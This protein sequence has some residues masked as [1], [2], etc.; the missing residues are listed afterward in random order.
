MEKREIGNI[1]KSVRIGLLAFGMGTPPLPFHAEWSRRRR[2]RCGRKEGRKE[3]A[4]FIPGNRVAKFHGYH[5]RAVCGGNG[6]LEGGREGG[7]A[8]GRNKDG[9]AVVGS[10]DCRSFGLPFCRSHC[11]GQHRS[12][13]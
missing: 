11:Q 2:H 8:S 13:V 4:L 5:V 3:E 10:T 12:R 6:G 9:G 7:T 1:S